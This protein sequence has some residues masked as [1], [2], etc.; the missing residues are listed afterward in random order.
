MVGD[1]NQCLASAD[2][3]RERPGTHCKGGWVLP[4]AG[5]HCCLIFLS[6]RVSIH[7]PQPIA[8]S[9]TD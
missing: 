1:I 6:N 3:P 8:S 7:G 9:Y 5:L 2:L 4:T